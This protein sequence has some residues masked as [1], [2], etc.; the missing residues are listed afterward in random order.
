MPNSMTEIDVIN[1][2]LIHLGDRRITSRTQ[3]DERAKTMNAI[4]DG[5]RDEVLRICP[6]TFARTR[7]SLAV[8]P[9]DPLWGFGNRYALPADFLYMIEVENLED[10]TIESG[11]IQANSTSG[12]ADTSLNVKYIRRVTDMSKADSLFVQALALKL[13]LKASERITQSNTKKD[14]FRFDYEEAVIQAMRLNGQ[15]LTPV[16]FKEDEWITEMR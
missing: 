4:Y 10:Y 9:T 5:T 13:A 14:Q 12:I 1:L 6:W 8:D 2:A 11:F 7:V 15:E 3:D 16:R